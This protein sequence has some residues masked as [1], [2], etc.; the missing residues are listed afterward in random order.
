M[1]G[2]FG[3]MASR[4]LETNS[5]YFE[6]EGSKLPASFDISELTATFRDLG[7]RTAA[8]AL[9]PVRA[10]FR[11]SFARV[12]PSQVLKHRRFVVESGG[13]NVVVERAA[14]FDTLFWDDFHRSVIQ[15]P[16]QDTQ[17]IQ[18]DDSNDAF[19]RISDEPKAIV[20]IL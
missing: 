10:A 17:F 3:T 2:A 20:R 7:G 12:A 15:Q 8:E 1:D 19:W 6:Y 11:K 16:P 5:I 4:L 9:E 13:E 14:A 18:W